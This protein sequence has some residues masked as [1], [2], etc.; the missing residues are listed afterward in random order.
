MNSFFTKVYT[1]SHVYWPSPPYLC[2]E[3]SQSYLKCNLLGYSPHFPPNK[4]NHET[5][6][7]CFFFSPN[8][9]T[10]HQGEQYEIVTPT[11]L[12]A[13]LDLDSL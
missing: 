2:G 12:E 11:E 9:S 3:V 13:S 1:K 6:M 5:L 4:T 8:V 10:L 7:L